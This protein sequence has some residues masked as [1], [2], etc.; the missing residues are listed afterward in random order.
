MQQNAIDLLVLFG[1]FLAVMSLPIWIGIIAV[2]R[3]KGPS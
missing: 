3:E 1:G 2:L